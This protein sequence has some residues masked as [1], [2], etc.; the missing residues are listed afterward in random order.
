MRHHFQEGART[1]PKRARTRSA[2]LD[3]AIATVAE[4]G[5]AEASVKAITATAGLSNGT[6][7]NY[8]TTREELFRE[9]AVAVAEA[10]TD[11]V[12]AEVLDVPSGTSRIV[13]STDA[14]LRKALAMPDWAAMIVDATHHIGEIRHDLGRHL[15]ADVALALERGEIGEVPHAFQLDQIGALVALGLEVQLTRGESPAIRRQTCD[16]V[17]R[18]LG[19]SPDEARDVVEREIPRTPA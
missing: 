1:K 17:L 3:G 12:A 18:L 15:R 4:R 7:Y 16:A 9:A 11:D 13:R 2:L 14:F 5:L 10:I 6:F 8:F 19:M